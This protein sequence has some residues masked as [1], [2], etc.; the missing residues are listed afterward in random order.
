MCKQTCTANRRT[1]LEVLFISWTKSYQGRYAQITTL[2]LSGTAGSSLGLCGPRTAS[3]SP[4]GPPLC[5]PRPQAGTDGSS[6]PGARAVGRQLG[7]HGSPHH[8]LPSAVVPSSWRRG[9]P[10]G[11][12]C[13]GP[14]PRCPARPE[15]GTAVPA[16]AQPAPEPR[17]QE[18]EEKVEEEETSRW[19]WSRG[20]CPRSGFGLEELTA[21]VT[22]SQH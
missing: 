18:E 14:I 9:A 16:C 10:R 17:G 22:L 7:G 11:P 6:L 19:A 12:P 8:S 4:P 2:F 5:R 20:Q 1:R 15:R 13:P 21:H 3:H